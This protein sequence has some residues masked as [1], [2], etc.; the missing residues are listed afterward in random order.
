MTTTQVSTP[1]STRAV[2]N[3]T[4]QK[5]YDLWLSELEMMVQAREVVIHMLID[6]RKLSQDDF[7]YQQAFLR[8]HL[9]AKRN[10]IEHDAPGKFTDLIS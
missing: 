1:S 9:V 10:E 4:E 8:Q 6:C 5:K 7:Y 2:P 3:E